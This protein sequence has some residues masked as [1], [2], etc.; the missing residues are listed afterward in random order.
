VTDEVTVEIRYDG[1]DITPYVMFSE[2]RFTSRANGQ[3]GECSIPLRDAFQVLQFVPGRT[4][5][6]YLNGSREWD[7]FLTNHK[8]AFFFEGH[9]ANCYPCT[10]LTPRKLILEG[11]DRNVYLQNRTLF[12][13]GDPTGESDRIFPAGTTDEEVITTVLDQYGTTFTGINYTTKVET[14]ASPDSF[15]EF[16]VPVQAVPVQDMLWVV[17]RGTGAVFYIDPDRF[18]VYTDV[19]TE[20][21]AYRISDHPTGAEVGC[22]DM[23]VL[24]DGSELVNDAIIW[25]AGMG[26]PEMVYARVQDSASITA[27]GRWQY[28]GN[29][30]RSNIWK[31]ESANRIA[32]TI[33]YGS[34]SNKR[35]HKDD[36]VTVLCTV[37]KPGLRVADKVLV[38]SDVHNYSDVV[39]IREMTI[40]FPTQTHAKYELRLSHEIDPPW[41]T[42]DP[43]IPGE[44]D[45]GPE[46]PNYDCNVF[47]HDYDPNIVIGGGSNQPTPPT[48]LKGPHRTYIGDR[49]WF[50]S[51]EA[52]LNL[53]NWVDDVPGGAAGRYGES[54]RAEKVTTIPGATSNIST[55]YEVWYLDSNQYSGIVGPFIPSRI[56]HSGPIAWS[57]FND[58]RLYRAPVTNTVAPGFGFYL[59][60]TGSV[61]LTGT[62]GG[63]LWAGVSRPVDTPVEQHKVTLSRLHGPGQREDD[64]FVLR[65]VHPI[66]DGA[67]ASGETVGVDVTLSS[68]QE[69]EYFYLSLDI[70]EQ[71]FDRP[72][73]NEVRAVASLTLTYHP[74]K[75]AG[76]WVPRATPEMPCWEVPICGRAC[77]TAFHYFGTEYRLPIAYIVGSTKV[78]ID[79]INQ[80]LGE[81]YNETDP[82]AGIIDLTTETDSEV[83]VCWDGIGIPALS[84]LPDTS[85]ALFIRPVSGPISG[86]FGAQDSGW[87]SAVWHGT[88]Y[89]HFHNGVDFSV[90]EGTPVYAAASGQVVWE[91]QF[92]GGDMIHIYHSNGMRTTYAHLSSR[93]VANGSSVTQGDLIALSGATGDVTG[94]HLHWGLVYAGSPEDPLPYTVSTSIVPIPRTAA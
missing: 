72:I 44:D 7:G 71:N 33:I 89:P 2:A 26:S 62:E 23:T 1:D 28:T 4:L 19:N 5:E 15:Q 13:P 34:P 60:I 79:G 3:T 35:G 17:Q 14:V 73:A 25:G 21:A 18:L 83:Y 85:T 80:V 61:T 31:Q 94:P 52:G 70:D 16:D 69:G 57:W 67:L 88:Y 30:F 45:Q 91:S 27:H 76:F 36:R 39:P 10:H 64:Y 11:L 24:K 50:V 77:A 41:M 40:T 56:I 8:Y 53:W 6:L 87:P 63:R 29:N 38:S 59:R 46:C 48:G 90:V 66:G 37:F 65:S 82:M 54:T 86:S 42:F 43:F 58:Y 32:N 68:I 84:P 92:A 93:L 22:R 75:P 55:G 47:V 9:T 78:T 20:N 81:D 49:Q 12:D 74:M 51:V